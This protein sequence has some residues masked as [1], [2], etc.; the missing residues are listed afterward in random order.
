MCK[1]KILWNEGIALYKTANVSLVS[2]P[3]TLNASSQKCFEQ[4]SLAEAPRYV[5][6]QADSTKDNEL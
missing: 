1:A 2:A 5:K 3:V 6:V 4:K